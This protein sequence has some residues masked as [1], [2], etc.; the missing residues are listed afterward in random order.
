MKSD[1]LA[2]AFSHIVFGTHSDSPVSSVAQQQDACYWREKEIYYRPFNG[3]LFYTAEFERFVVDQ[4][5]VWRLL[6]EDWLQNT[7]TLVVFFETLQQ[8][9]AKRLI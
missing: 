4:S 1:Q 3:S 9:K 5:K 8:K 2:S 6:A 7:D